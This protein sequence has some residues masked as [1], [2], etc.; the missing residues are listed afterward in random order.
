M[1][2]LI[3]V[4]LLIAAAS[5]G[6]EEVQ[7]VLAYD[8]CPGAN[9]CEPICVFEDEVPVCTDLECGGAP[10]DPPGDCQLFANECTFR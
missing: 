7:C 4:P 1:R 10:N 8:T 3:W 5:C 2:R 9:P 6:E